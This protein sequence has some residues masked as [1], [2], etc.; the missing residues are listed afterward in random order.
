MTK[1]A[2]RITALTIPSTLPTKYMG[3]NIFVAGSNTVKVNIALA[4]IRKA[5]STI[6]HQN[7]RGLNL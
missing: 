5:A 7:A 3:M 6:S 2:L 1:A 4:L